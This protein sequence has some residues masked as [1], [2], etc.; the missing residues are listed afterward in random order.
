MTSL[1]I[2]IFFALVVA[3]FIVKNKYKD[4]RLVYLRNQRNFPLQEACDP[5]KKSSLI[6]IMPLFHQAP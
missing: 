2:I 4:Q 1:L 5:K 3:L 6:T